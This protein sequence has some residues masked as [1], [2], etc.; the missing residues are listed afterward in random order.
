M[1]NGRASRPTDALS[2]L[3]YT[4]GTPSAEAGCLRPPG[5]RQRILDTRA[6]S[7]PPGGWSAAPGLA[8]LSIDEIAVRAAPRSPA[9]RGTAC[10][11]PT[12]CYS[13]RWFSTSPRGSR[14]RTSSPPL[15]TGTPR[16]HPAD[17]RVDRGHPVRPGR[18]AAADRA[19][20][21]KRRPQHRRR[22]PPRPRPRHR[23]QALLRRTDPLRLDNTPTNLNT[24]RCLPAGTRHHRAG[25]A[26]QEHAA[27]HHHGTLDR[28][29]APRTPA[30]T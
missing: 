21:D 14:S 25:R 17:P 30:T 9:R 1:A 15:R 2:P 13:T 20:T 19:R 4:V 18:S 23:I 26:T 22:P 27:R 24:A 16:A 5:A 12:P 29:V 3:T 8:E 7:T 6:S 10:S 11:L 28:H